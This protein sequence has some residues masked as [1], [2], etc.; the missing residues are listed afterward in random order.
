[1]AAGVSVTILGTAQDGGIPQAGCSCERCKKAH[2]DLELRKY[3]VSLGILGADGSKHIVEVTKNLC[4]QLMIWAPDEN[5]LFIPETVSITH[6]HLGHVEGIGQFGKPVMALKEVDIFLS[7]DNKNI[8]DGRSDIELMIKENNI[9][10]HSKDFYQS[11]EPKEGC[12]FSLQF[13]PI[14]HRSELGDTAAIIIKGNKKNILF[15]PDQDSW[16]ETLEHYSK[17]NIRDFL[18]MF[19][20]NEALIDGTFWSMEELPGRNI[21][22]IPHPTIQESLQLLGRKMEDDPRISFLHLNHS[23]PVNDIGSKQ[24]K[25]VEE[26]GW[27]I[28]EIGDV[29]KL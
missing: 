22:E 15:M 17:E 1:M 7:R 24:R 14:P 29:L 16:K 2:K 26:N 20:I 3:P 27:K 19:D 10:T 21:S 23:N 28:S 8:F 25:L 13:I 12:G 9:K 6:L 4:E 5:E 11:F 18:K